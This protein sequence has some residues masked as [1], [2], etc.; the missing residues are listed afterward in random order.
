M[1]KLIMLARLLREQKQQ[2]EFIDS[3]YQKGLS[4]PG[5]AYDATQKILNEYDIK[6]KE[7]LNEPVKV[8]Y[9]VI[10]ENMYQQDFS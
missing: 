2:L 9:D 7:L 3:C 4:T 10:K 8:K 5:E 6:W 1:N